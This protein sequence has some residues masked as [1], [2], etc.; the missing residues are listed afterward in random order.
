MREYP[1][2]FI[3]TEDVDIA[4]RER[5][6]SFGI[7]ISHFSNCY[8]LPGLT[9]VHVHLREPGFL[10]KETM[11][12]GTLSAAAGGFTDIFSMPNLDPCPDTVENLE[13]QLAAIERDACVR[14]Y[15]YGAITMG[16]RGQE[17]SDM[18]RLADHVIAFTDDGR[19][20]ASEEMM[21]E[22]MKRAKALG[23]LIVAHCEDENFPKESSESEWKQLE[24]DIRL[25]RETG[26][27]Y[28][29]CHVSTRESIEL[30]RKAKEE[31]LDI[32][33]ETAP[34]YL[35]IS[36][37]QVEDDGRFKM[38]PPIKG[39]EDREVLLEAIAD[40]TIDMIA[41]DHAPH[42]RDEKSRGFAD[43]AFGIVG[44][45]TAFPVMYTKLV[46]TGIITADR[47]IKLMCDGPRKRFGLPGTSIASEL[48]SAAPTFSIW[49]LDSRYRIDPEGFQSMGRSCPFEGWTVTGRC[50]LTAV[51]G[52][53][54]WRY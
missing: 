7:D 39:P 15:P 29:V 27:S 5:L 52:K 8:I 40:G 32:T 51:D 2:K 9:D 20:V 34:H 21:R 10:Y 50:L 30:V 33:C 42:S 3:K 43:S 48:S 37:D 4:G 22:A 14:V 53:V 47:L 38:N 13:I 17:L 49:D 35:T 44:M 24:R 54:V 41:T 23:K 36:N 12:T 6:G 28:H 18:E 26:C 19:G 46:E 25:I 31:G 16:E 45:E 1:E 11:K